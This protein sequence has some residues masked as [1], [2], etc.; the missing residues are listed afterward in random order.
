MFRAKRVDL[1][2]IRVVGVFGR[3]AHAGAKIGLRRQDLLEGQASESLDNQAQAAVG[4]LE[5]LVDVRG[6][7][8][9]V[10]VGL[11][12]LFDRRIALREHGDQLAVGD[13]VVDQPHGALASHR[14]RHEGIRK[15][16]RVPQ[17]QNRQLGRDAE[18]PIAQREV[19]GLEVLELIAHRDLTLSGQAG[20]RGSRII[21]RHDPTTR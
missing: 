7:A 2:P 11:P 10:Q 19:L 16:D 15:Q 20:D 12:R 6:R 9:R 5:H 17:R 13:R 3:R 1:Q 18:R 4:Q 21:R 14:Q 8:D